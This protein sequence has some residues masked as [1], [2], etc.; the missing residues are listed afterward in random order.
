MAQRGIDPLLETLTVPNGGVEF[1]KVVDFA[2]DLFHGFNLSCVLPAGPHTEVT[3]FEAACSHGQTPFFIRCS[4]RV[5]AQRS[6]AVAK[7][8]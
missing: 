1:E 5:G 2:E 4:L 7:Q 6:A 8:R 3:G